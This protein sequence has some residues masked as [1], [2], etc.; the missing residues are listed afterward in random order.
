MWHEQR[1]QEKK[2]KGFL[3]DR[4]K[5]AERRRDYYE[6]FKADPTQFLQVH[7][8]KTKIHLDPAV[9]LA[10]DSPTTMMPW[11]GDKNIQI[12]RF[13]VRAHLDFI[14]EYKADKSK[15]TL[16][17]EEEREQ[18]KVNYERYRIL[19]QNDYL[20]IGEVKFLKTIDLEEK[21]GGTTYQQQKAKEDKKRLGSSKAAIGFV[22]EDSAPVSPPKPDDEEEEEDSDTDSEPDFDL[23]VDVLS[24]DPENQSEINKLGLGYS[25]GKKDFVKLLARDV[26][27]AEEL[28]MAREKEVEKSM[29]SGRK[30]RRQRRALREKRITERTMSPPAYA[31]R[32]SPE[33]KDVSRSRSRSK[34]SDS[35]TGNQK[36]EFITSFGGD[37]PDL[38]KEGETSISNKGNTSKQQNKKSDLSEYSAPIGPTLPPGMET[39]AVEK[40]RS[41]SSDRRHRSRSHDRRKRRSRERSRSRHGRPQE[42]RRRSRERKRSRSGSRRGSYRSSRDHKRSRSSERNHT[43]APYPVPPR[44]E[45][46]ENKDELQNIK[47]KLV[48]K[49]DSDSSDSSEDDN[50]DG[51]KYRSKY[52]NRKASSSSSGEES[53][54]SP[55]HKSEEIK[56]KDDDDVDKNKESL[57]HHSMS[58]FF[59]G[60]TGSVQAEPSKQ[61]A[62]LPAA[63]QE[64]EP[65]PVIKRYY[66][67]R[68]EEKSSESDISVDSDEEKISALKAKMKVQKKNELQSS[69][70]CNKGE[71][72]N[73][74]AVKD[75]IRKKMLS[76]IKKTFKEDKKMELE[77]TR[78]AEEEQFYREEELRELS[79]KLRVRERE[80]RRMMRGSSESSRSRSRSRSGSR[81]RTKR[82]VSRNRS[83]S[84]SANRSR[85]ESES[86]IKRKRSS[87]SSRNGERHRPKTQTEDNN[88][89][90]RSKT[91]KEDNNSDRR[92]KTQMEDNN[93]EESDRRLVDY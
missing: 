27:E 72:A 67:R 14:E 69:V 76:Q 25:L 88:S 70:T 86:R 73:L 47:K 52:R 2:I 21:F 33:Y 92:P 46:N 13:D 29:Y 68:H 64:D 82:S 83:R 32:D 40:R 10:A 84:K 11:M 36:V 77:R 78:K 91:Q 6:K 42:R 26:E 74:V 43:L 5:R 79:E 34:S 19:V 93:S 38:S 51:T 54:E 71:S 66:G 63:K 28:K 39:V 15:P 24:L 75:K 90:R 7:G 65:A 4:Q 37:S 80:R 61:A 9:S 60:F 22:Y 62:K 44:P 50:N 30:S 53:N 18:R 20:G 85:S 12:D 57:Y 17:S 23:T 89:D 8:R 31:A 41:K 35:D 58:S 56:Q 59:S 81:S 48:T 55:K 87:S 3:V 49:K 1:K 45:T 16:D